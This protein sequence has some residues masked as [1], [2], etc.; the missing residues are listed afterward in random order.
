MHGKYPQRR[1]KI[2]LCVD[3][4]SPI[5]PLAQGPAASLS[6]ELKIIPGKEEDEGEDRGQET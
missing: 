2:K 6:G 3:G 1:G 5:W 4:K